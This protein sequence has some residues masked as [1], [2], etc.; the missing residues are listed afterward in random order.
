MSHAVH[1]AL[2][3]TAGMIG[4]GGCTAP[5]PPPPIASQTVSTPV[6]AAMLS[7]GD[8]PPSAPHADW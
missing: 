6:A 7:E 8:G 1:C 3:A 2:I 5:Q 4:L